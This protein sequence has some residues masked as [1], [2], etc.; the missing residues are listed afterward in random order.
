MPTDETNR[1]NALVL[2]VLVE[3]GL[4][5]VACVA[6]WF[7]GIRPWLQF[8]AGAGDAALGAAAALPILA[9]FV[10]TM[11]SRAAP[12]VRI[13][14][15]LDEVLGPLFRRCSLAELALLSALA[16][17]GEE[18]LFRGV[19]QTWLASLLGPTIGLFVASALFGLAHSITPTYAL[20]AGLIGAYL[21]WLWIATGNLLVPALAH[22][23]YDFAALVYLLRWEQ[24]GRRLLKRG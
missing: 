23:L 21:G 6:G 14:R 11:N 7:L 19:L 15:F 16:G 12:L 8:D 9:G 10:L 22:G 13:H 4:G 5:V 17:A 18:M 20:V 1:R 2:G 24:R 3:G